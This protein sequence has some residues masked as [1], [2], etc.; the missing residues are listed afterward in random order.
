MIWLTWRQHRKQALFAVIG[1]AVLA[2]VLIPTGLQMYDAL[3]ETGLRA[4]A[5]SATP[6]SWPPAW[7]TPAIRPP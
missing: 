6:N 2:A 3:E 1:L 4:C 5:R 7:S